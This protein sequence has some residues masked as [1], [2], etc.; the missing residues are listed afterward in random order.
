MAIPK[1]RRWQ[2]GIDSKG[3]RETLTS[4]AKQGSNKDGV[5]VVLIMTALAQQNAT[6]KNTTERFAV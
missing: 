3:R 4:M 1:H 6:A 2:Q 5:G